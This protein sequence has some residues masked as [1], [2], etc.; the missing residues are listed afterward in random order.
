SIGTDRMLADQD[1]VTFRKSVTAPSRN[2]IFHV[3]AEI[4]DLTGLNQL[5]PRLNFTSWA[6]TIRVK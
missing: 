4:I 3:T 2:G 1:G 6:A 5:P